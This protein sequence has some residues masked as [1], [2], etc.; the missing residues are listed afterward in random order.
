MI[1]G[2]VTAVACILLQSAASLFLS[3][4]LCPEDMDEETAERFCHLAAHPISINRA[5]KSRLVETGLFS[6]FQI[7]SLLEY[8]ERSGDILSF[9]EL[10][11][12]DGWNAEF[13]DALREY[14]DLSG[15]DIPG[16]SSSRKSF[17]GQATGRYGSNSYL[18]KASM[19]WN[20]RWSLFASSKK[21]RPLNLSAARYGNGP[22]SKVVIGNYNARFAQG[23]AVWSGMRM[24]GLATVEALSRRESGVSAS[25]STSA[26]C[27]GVAAEFSWGPWTLSAGTNLEQE[28]EVLRLSALA[29]L[30]YLWKQGQC[31]ISA[32]AGA[33]T[34]VVSANWKFRLGKADFYGEA[35]WEFGSRA[36]AV[37]AGIRMDPKWKVAWGLTARYYSPAFRAKWSGAPGSFSKNSD[38]AGLAAVLRYLWLNIAVDAA[39]RPEKRILQA[40]TSV[41][42]SPTIQ[43]GI[44]TLSPTLKYAIR[45]KGGKIPDNSKAAALRNELRAELKASSGPWQASLRGDCTLCRNFAWLA[46][47][48]AGFKNGILNC[49]LHAEYFDIASWDDR[50]YVYQRDVPGSFNVPA[51]YGKGFSASITGGFILGGG[52]PR[53]T[54]R[55]NIRAGAVLYRRETEK[56][57]TS[58]WRVQYAF[59]W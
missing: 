59:N 6:A 4:A 15:C 31:G 50:I 22:L 58:E 40:K 24:S 35:A 52:K 56:P 21:A 3:G 18:T 11:R 29:N 34:Q 36:P 54:H 2:L 41:K 32:V 7:A 53:F 57:S 33:G 42:F 30:N 10:A 46:L 55:L 14:V 45:W 19:E 51:R 39:Y 17:H 5:S 38:E 23:L 1:H 37:I 25:Q 8:R 9:A 44:F 47:A 26:A 48:E 20:D 16:R 12:L 28:K 49:F 43:A 27:N 13:A